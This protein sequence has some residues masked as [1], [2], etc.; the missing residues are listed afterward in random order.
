MSTPAQKAEQLERILDSGTLKGSVD[1]QAV[2]F[3][4][5]D[6][7]R[8]RIR[9]LRDQDCNTRGRRPVAS[10]IKLGGW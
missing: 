10:T 3:V 5:T 4:S 2:E 8:Q 9:E 1:G 7:I 6:A